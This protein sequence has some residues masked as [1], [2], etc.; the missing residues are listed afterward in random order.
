MII[1]YLEFLLKVIVIIA[2][3]RLLVFFLTHSYY[4]SQVRN[5]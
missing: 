3:V 2:Y 5:R 4:K 1:N